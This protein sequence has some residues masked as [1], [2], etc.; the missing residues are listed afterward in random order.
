MADRFVRRIPEPTVVRLPVY[1]ARPARPFCQRRPNRLVRRARGGGGVNAAKVRKDL[2]H[3]GTYGTPGTGYD[4]NFLLG[5]VRRE[6]GLDREW[7]V[8]I[9]GMGNL[10]HALARS[11]RFSTQNFRAVA[12][13]DV[14]PEKIGEEVAGLPVRD[15]SRAA[16]RRR[17]HQPVDRR[18]RHPGQRRPGRVQPARGGGRPGDLELRPGNLDGAAP[19]A[20]PPGR[21]LRRAAGAGLLR[22]APG[23]HQP[24]GRTRLH[25]G[26][27]GHRLSPER[28]E[29]DRA[30]AVVAVGINERD[31]SLDVFEQSAI[32]ERDLPKALQ[33]L[34]SSEHISEAVVLSTCLRTEVYAVVERFHD[35]LADIE[36]FFRSYSAAMG[37]DS[38]VLSELLS[39]WV[40]DAAVS[41]LFEVAAGI[42]SPVLGEGEILRQVR[43][44]ADL[45]R[46]EH[47]A[48]LTLGPLFRHAVEAGK[49]V[50]SETAIS[51]GTTSLAHAAVALAADHL[52]GGLAGRTVLVIGAG[53]MGA[54]F[55]KALAQPAAPARV[56]VANRS[57]ERAQPW[58]S[59]PVRTR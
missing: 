21:F 31:V 40:D 5:Q 18:D 37:T 35:G 56:V 6:L 28:N 13:F 30:V 52:E 46:R 34:C 4:V 36:S 3:L 14:D 57:S 32:S 22:S 12:L 8:V 55:S 51:Q 48:G 33:V 2:S 53:E 49:R 16:G 44:A 50:R 47:A 1:R 39:C 7:Q 29:V 11:Q 42:D 23:S 45:A 27:D 24:M 26:P 58:P 20:V 10:G 15:M 19:C 43:T 54:G 38:E 41:H 9:V 59:S 17:G 25:R